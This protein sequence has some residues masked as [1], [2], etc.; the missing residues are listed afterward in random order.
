MLQLHEGKYHFTFISWRTQTAEEDKTKIKQIRPLAI[1][2]DA[3]KSL[4]KEQTVAQEKET[5]T[6][7]K[8]KKQ[9]QKKKE[10]IFLQLFIKV[11]ETLW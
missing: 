6:Q 1:I 4:K 10:I 5:R 9:R 8:N 11:S 2:K 3:L 7:S